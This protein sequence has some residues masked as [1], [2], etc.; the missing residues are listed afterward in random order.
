MAEA[1]WEKPQSVASLR[2]RAFPKRAKFA[3]VGGVLLLGMALLML[4]GTLSSGQYFMTVQAMM[5]RPDLAGKTI[6]ISGAVVGSTIKYDSAANTIHFTMANITNDTD[7]IEKEG[8]LGAAL[9]LAVIDPK[10]QRIAIEVPN[11]PIPDL[12]KD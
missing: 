12:L 5:E 10:A 2:A 8:G 4:A 3:I 6:K 7:E 9:H 1:T 11:Q